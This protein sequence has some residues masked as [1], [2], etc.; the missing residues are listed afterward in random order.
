MRP[1]HWLPL[2]L[3]SSSR[4]FSSTVVHARHG[5]SPDWPRVVHGALLVPPALPAGNALP[6]GWMH[7]QRPTHRLQPALLKRARS[8]HVLAPSSLWLAHRWQTLADPSSAH[9]CS[10]PPPPTHTSPALPPRTPLESQRLQSGVARTH[11]IVILP[12]A[13]P[14]CLRHC[15]RQ[16]H[17]AQ[18]MIVPR[19]ATSSN[20]VPST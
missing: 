19:P 14:G 11:S 6:A 10:P 13:S 15:C 3:P 12:P 8:P 4:P 16:Y 7:N 18:R 5:R 9:T 1:T 20:L 2:C 17:H